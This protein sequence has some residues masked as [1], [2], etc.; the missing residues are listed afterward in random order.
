MRGI[1]KLSHW[2]VGFLVVIS[3]ISSFAK[4]NIESLSPN[5]KQLL[6]VIS[7][8][9]DADTATLQRFQRD[10]LDRKWQRVG[11]SIPVVI[12]KHGMAWSAQLAH[13]A[14]GPIKKE[15]D[16]RTPAGIFSFGTAFGFAKQPDFSLQLS[17]LPITNNTVCVDDQKSKYYN[18]IIDSSKVEKGSWDSGEQMIK[19][20]PYYTWGVVINYNQPKPVIGGGSCIFMHV[21]GGPQH[22]T[23]GCVAMAQ[24]NIQ[25]VLSWINPQD[26]PII[27]I[28]PKNDYDALIKDNDLPKLS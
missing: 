3:S 17:Y 15:G 25:K 20:V 23:S 13:H 26:H 28:F 27:V 22:G 14:N 1:M 19:Q 7:D 18:Q 6:V 5:V 24:P 21:W 4:N 10:S 12:G 9:W 16:L 11:D 8:N 2:Y